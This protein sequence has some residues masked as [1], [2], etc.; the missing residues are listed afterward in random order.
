MEYATNKQAR[1]D[2]NLQDRFTA[3]IKLTGAEVKSVKKGGMRL[4]SAFV[5]LH[6]GSLFLTNAHIAAYKPAGPQPSYEPTR[7]RPLLLKKSE[8]RSIIGQLNQ[9]GLTMVP[10]RAIGV[11]NLIK[12]EFAIGRGKRQYE[13]RDLLKKREADRTINVAMRRRR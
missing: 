2:Y 4:K 1:R 8:L 11:R 3:G 13:K 6:K 9:K 10:L 5:T 7:S 12:I